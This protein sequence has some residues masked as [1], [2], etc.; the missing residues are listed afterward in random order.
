MTN[1]PTT[2]D[3]AQQ[4]DLA[5][6]LNAAEPGKL[7]VVLSTGMPQQRNQTATGSAEQH[8]AKLAVNGSPRTW[9]WV[10]S[11]VCCAAVSAILL[12]FDVV[13]SIPVNCRHMQQFLFMC[14]IHGWSLPWQAYWTYLKP[15]IRSGRACERGLVANNCRSGD[16]G[17]N[18]TRTRISAPHASCFS[19]WLAV[20]TVS[21]D[22]TI[23]NRRYQRFPTAFRSEVLLIMLIQHQRCI[24]MNH[25]G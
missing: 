10:F 17:I 8:I 5:E 9:S 22:L 24:L 6:K 14:L 23:S 25:A 12:P 19:S 13:E 20:R 2:D 3:A 1:G 18:R 21:L 15:L 16:T 4:H 7:L 11:L